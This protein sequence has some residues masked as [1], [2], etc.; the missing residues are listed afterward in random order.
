MTIQ[1][2]P[3]DCTGCG[4]CIDTCPARSKEV[5]KHKS[6][7]AAPKADH[8]ERER[9]SWDFFLTIPE[10]DRT[11][12]EVG[13]VKGSQMLEPLFEFSGACS[14]CGETPYLK[15][16]TQ[17]F[18]DRMLVAN[19]TGCSSIYGGNLPTTPWSAERGRPRPGLVELA[20]R[21]QRGVRARHAPRAR[22]PGGSGRGARA[23]ARSR[24][25]A[26]RCSTPTSRR[27]RDRGAA[28]SA[29]RELKARLAGDAGPRRRACSPSPTRSSARASGSSAATA[30]PTTS[31]SAASTTC[32]PRAAT[33]TSSCSTPRSTRTPAAR[34]RRRP[35]AARS[36]SSRPAGKR[37]RK[38]DLGLIASAYGDVYVAQIAMGADNPQT[39]KAFAEAEAYPG[40][41][42]IIAYC[43]CIAHGIDM[44]T[45]WP[46]RSRRP[47]PATGRSTATTR[48][49]HHPLQ[50]DSRAAED[51]ALRLH[52]KEA[53]FSMLARARP[54]DA[55]RLAAR[56]SARR[57]RA[58]QLYEQLA[59]STKRPGQRR[60]T[61]RE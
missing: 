20:V 35:R 59:G 42:L 49:S 11:P 48:G 21:G 47:T 46:I 44:E 16:L 10:I 1:I 32:S 9:A 39:V 2:A 41:S 15:L 57:R 26:A 22:P 36:R 58:R 28:G 3:D 33:S 24:S 40:V 7:D 43:H 61:D 5:A 50:L 19:A 14:G 52:R 45:A 12:V 55:E 23:R 18:G 34:P 37:T 51:A 17:M 54:E 38:K 13:T 60:G 6:L 53:R 30:G 8:L 4:I 31:A 56:G 25:R 27:G 29:W